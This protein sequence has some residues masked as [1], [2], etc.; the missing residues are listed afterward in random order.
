MD[1]FGNFKGTAPVL[2]TPPAIPILSEGD[3]FDDNLLMIGQSFQ[4]VEKEVVA[5]ER[6]EPNRQPRPAQ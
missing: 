2:V 4:G 5:D 6:M 1:E 3:F